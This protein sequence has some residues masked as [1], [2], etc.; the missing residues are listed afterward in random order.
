LDLTIYI[1]RPQGSA[2]FA[3][4]VPKILTFHPLSLA[5]GAENKADL[6]FGTALAQSMPASHFVL[7]LFE[8]MFEPGKS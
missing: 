3:D 5:H 1:S 7:W 6:H 2:D 4:P 8:I